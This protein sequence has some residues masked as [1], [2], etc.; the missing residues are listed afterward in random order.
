MYSYATANDYAKSLCMDIKDAMG[1][2]QE[3][4]Q[5]MKLQLQYRW[6]LL[7]RMKLRKFKELLDSGIISKR[8]L[9]QEKATAWSVV[10]TYLLEQDICSAPFVKLGDI[11]R[12]K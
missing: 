11:F 3:E 8:N 5:N 12:D 2:Y 7:L 4:E 9:T 10:Y 1:K 6:H